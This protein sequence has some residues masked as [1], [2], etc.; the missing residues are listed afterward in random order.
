LFSLSLSTFLFTVSPFFF[1]FGTFW[2][3]FSNIFVVNNL[4]AKEIRVRMME[5]R[6]A[7]ACYRSR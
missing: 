4:R 2:K 3:R 1:A 7:L 5:K 6:G